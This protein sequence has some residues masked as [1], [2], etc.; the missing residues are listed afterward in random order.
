MEAQFATDLLEA[1]EGPA[2]R[3]LIV[4]DDDVDRERLRRMLSKSDIK[5][6][7][8]EAVSVEESLAYS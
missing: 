3:L 5:T 8:S 6:H 2:L 4:D 1:Y 7:V